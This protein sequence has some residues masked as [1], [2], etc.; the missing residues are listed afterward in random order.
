MKRL[1][2]LCAGAVM[3]LSATLGVATMASAQDTTAPAAGAASGP[4]ADVPTDHWA[5]Q[6]VDTLQK[7]GIVI[8]YPDG[9]YGGRRAMTRY[10]F[11]V[12]IARLLPLINANAASKSDLSALQQEEDAK[13]EQNQQ[14]LDALKSLVDEFQPELQQLGQD[15]AAVKS[16]LDA[17]EARLAAVEDEQRRVKINGNV[18]FIARGYVN[19]STLDTAPL[20]QDGYRVGSA[21]SNAVN[22]GSAGFGAIHHSTGP[23]N[24]IGDFSTSPNGGNTSLWNDIQW[25]NDVLLTID[26]R[27]SDNA[28]A[29][30]KLEGGTY[31]PYLGDLTAI[32]DERINGAPTA[33]DGGSFDNGLATSVN[34]YEAYLDM[35]VSL[36]GLS[37]AETQIGR[38]PNQFTKWTMQ[39]LNPDSY[40]AIPETSSGD[41]PMD[42][43]KLLF[44]AGPAHVQLY[45]AKNDLS[46][47]WVEMNAGPN[48]SANSGPFRPGSVLRGGINNTGFNPIG[49]PSS[50]TEFVIDQSAGGRVTIGNPSNWVLGITGILARVDDFSNSSIQPVDPYQFSKNPAANPM[51]TYDTLEIFGADFN[52]VLPFFGKSGLTLSADFTETPTG[53]NSRFGN[54]NSS[55]ANQAFDGVLGWAT[56]PFS[57]KGGYEVVYGNFGAPGNWGHLGT[58]I[59]PVNIKGETASASYAI[60]P[61]LVLAA[62]GDWFQGAEATPRNL[63][64]NFDVQSP[65]TNTGDKLNHYDVGLKY[66]LT[67]QYSVDLGYEYDQW[68][69]N[70]RYGYLLGPIGTHHNPTEQY[71][72]LGVGHSF[73][74]NASMKILYQILTYND[75]SSGFDDFA[76]TPANTKGHENGGV[77]ITQ[78]SLMF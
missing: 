40:A 63:V 26:G 11:A 43:A 44:S 64:N 16:R 57:I 59:N 58:W 28:H 66:G 32:E 45:A 6:A 14:A 78:F 27:V 54:L 12:A 17:L 52:G 4:F 61:K 50:D 70:D 46:G 75:D 42:G 36:G 47:D 35:P 72:T 67:S 8:G 38:F 71:I 65:L 49:D 10:E 77:A 48:V 37:G 5:Y 23:G 34:I 18:N 51:K 19:T 9:T 41:Y 21:G 68:Q 15:V 55:H 60:S 62:D 20:D 1:V 53:S 24:N 30:I 3:L 7:A 13:I 2:T 22:P 29:I 69:L 73:N 74:K 25:Y 56:G 31:A 76:I 39:A 33:G